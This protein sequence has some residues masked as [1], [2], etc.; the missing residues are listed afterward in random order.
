ME[1]FATSLI[2]LEII[3]PASGFQGDS[4]SETYTQL[5]TLFHDRQVDGS[6]VY[7]MRGK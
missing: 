7:E 3:P 2:V 6:L 1:H 4:R 5:G